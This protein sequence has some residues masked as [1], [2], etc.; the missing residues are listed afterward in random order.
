LEKTKIIEEIIKYITEN[1][2]N[3]FIVYFWIITHQLGRM[4]R[5]IEYEV[6][7]VSWLDEYLLSRII[8]ETFR[9]LG[10]D[11]YQVNRQLLLLKALIIQNKLFDRN[12]NNPVLIF[13]ELIQNEEAQVFLQ[14]NRYQG[15]LYLSK[16]SLEEILAAKFYLAVINLSL[17]KDKLTPKIIEKKLQLW[18]K[19]IK[20]IKST[21]KKAKYRVEKIRECL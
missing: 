20:K 13:T 17:E 14:V 15:I 5:E 6:Q 10:L 8:A 16:E 18:Y 1:Q 19:N 9:Q 3:R 4:K 21:A 11:D 7:S 2:N 12:E